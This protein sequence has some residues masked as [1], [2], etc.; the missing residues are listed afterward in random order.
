LFRRDAEWVF[1][2]H[3]VWGAMEQKTG[4]RIVI[5]GVSEGTQLAMG[6]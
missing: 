2:E 1:V 5:G 6:D 4:L 3:G